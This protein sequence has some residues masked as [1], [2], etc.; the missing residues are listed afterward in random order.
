MDR[1]VVELKKGGTSCELS[2][3]HLRTTN[4]ARIFKVLKSGVAS[5]VAHAIHMHAPDV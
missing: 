1:E 5:C 2:I 3:S 4:I